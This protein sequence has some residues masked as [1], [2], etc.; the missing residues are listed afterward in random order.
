MAPA[1]FSWLLHIVYNYRSLAGCRKS[2]IFRSV[3]C[4]IS[5]RR[6][7][8]TEWTFW[9]NTSTFMKQDRVIKSKENI[10]VFWITCR[11]I[12][13]TAQLK[14]NPFIVM[15]NYSDETPVLSLAVIFHTAWVQ[16]QI[17][18]W[19]WAVCEGEISGTNPCTACKVMIPVKRLC[20]YVHF[21]F[22]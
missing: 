18:A 16:C 4:V 1:V 7:E 21:L 9:S 8:E 2:Q 13:S 5:L 6:E 3:G 17:G 12:C 14:P 11:H 10:S 19:L 20:M 15:V 22:Q